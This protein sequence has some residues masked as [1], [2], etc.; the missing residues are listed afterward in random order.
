VARA[1]AIGNLLGAHISALQGSHRLVFGDCHGYPTADLLPKRNWEAEVRH[2]FDF[3][4][5]SDRSLDPP[6]V[7]DVISYYEAAAPDRLPILPLTPDGPGPVRSLVRGEIAGPR[8]NEATA[9]SHVAL[10]HLTDPNLP[11]LLAC[12]MASGEL[13]IR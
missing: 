13:L 3:Y 7:Q 1:I 12:D 11:D 2:G 10:V 4:R 6:P 5:N 8:P 9:I